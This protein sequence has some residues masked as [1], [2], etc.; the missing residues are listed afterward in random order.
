MLLGLDGLLRWRV[1]LPAVGPGQLAA[2][3]PDLGDQLGQRHVPHL[4]RPEQHRR[5]DPDHPGQDRGVGRPV[6]RWP[7]RH[8]RLGV[9]R[10]LRHPDD[11][12]LR[13]LLLRRQ[14]AAAP[15][16][17][18]LATPA[19][20][21]YSSRSGRSRS[22]RPVATSSARWL[23]PPSPRSSTRCSSPSSACRTGCRSVSSPASSGSSSRPS[24]PTS[25]WPCRRSSP[26]SR[27][28]DQRPVDRALRHRLPADRE[29][30]LHPAH[31]P[32]DHGRPSSGRAGLGHRGRGTV[33]ADRRAHRDPAGRGRPVDHRHVHPAPSSCCP[34][35]RRSRMPRTGRTRTPAPSR[36]GIRRGNRTRRPHLQPIAPGA[37]QN[38]LSTPGSGSVLVQVVRLRR[39]ARVLVPLLEA[40][41]FVRRPGQPAGERLQAGGGQQLVGR[42]RRPAVGGGGELGGPP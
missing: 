7:P 4:V 30:R 40:Y 12:R 20:Q 6:R 15:D 29:L 8:L 17:R 39:V 31:Q 2:E 11:P 10:D 36:S 3:H 33:R 13:L 37:S 5:V 14:P 42:P 19:Y 18:L 1:R 23:W 41:P 26:W 38:Q 34:S 24:A 16:H 35:S 28:A 21:R 9:R 25:A 27:P 22:R 32:P